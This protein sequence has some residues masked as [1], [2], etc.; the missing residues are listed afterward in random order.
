MRPV[1]FF[2]AAASLFALSAAQAMPDCA[3]KCLATYLPASGCNATDTNCI[4]ANEAL[5]GAVETCTLGNCTIIEAL[6][7][8][9][10]TQTLCGAEV[11]DITSI[12]PIVSATSGLLAIIFT[13]LRLWDSYSVGFSWADGFALAAL[14]FSLPMGI[15]EFFMS[16][17][18]FGKDIWTLTPVRITRIVKFTWLTELFYFIAVGLTKLS[19]LMFY[20]RIFPAKE[21][22][23]YVLVTSGF[24]AAETIAF[25]LA[26]IFH[27]T[28]FEYGWTSWT[29]ETTGTCFNFNAFAWAHAII[30]IVADAWVMFMPIPQL[31]KLQ[32]GTRRKVHLIL[33]FCVGIFITIVS[34]VRLASL[35]QF[36]NTSNATYDNVP[37]AYWSVL[38]CYVSVICCCLP[39][40]RSILRRAVPSCFGST[41]DSQS[42]QYDASGYQISGKPSAIKKSVTNTVTFTSRENENGSD[43][44]EL[45]DKQQ[46]QQHTSNGW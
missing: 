8:Q 20:L 37:T 10:A 3:A 22:R 19:I 5:M 2:A 26:T 16:A 28:P 30:N 40:A 29:G 38:E 7:A 32:L 45:V 31:L 1:A 13:V 24:V 44:V 21:F 15:L 18:G 25:T 9:N 11:R 42:R 23:N 6:A 33:M 39:A 41:N 43:I 46:P 36:A 34:I 4:C 14:I 17:D 35:L 27:C 12:T